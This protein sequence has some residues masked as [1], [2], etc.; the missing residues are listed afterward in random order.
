MSEVADALRIPEF[1]LVVLVGASGAGKSTFAAKHFLPT[2]VISSDA[3][4][5]LVSDD[6][7]NQDVSREAFEVLEFVA[8]KRLSAR[9]LTVIDATN[10]Q[11]DARK[12]LVALARKYHAMPVAIALNVPEKLCVARNRERSDRNFGSGVIRRQVQSLRRSLRALK[13]EGF[14]YTHRLNSVDEVE[15]ATI[16]RQPLW[17]DRRGDHGPFDIIGDIHGCRAE[18]ESLLQE[19]GY[20]RD[21][22]D[23]PYRHPEGRRAVF[24]G[25]L[26]DRGPDTPG[27]IRTVMGMVQAE[28]GLC[29]AGNHDQKLHRKLRGRDVRITHGLA[30]SLTQLENQPPEFVEQAMGFFDSLLSHYWLDDGKLVVAHAGLRE[31]LQGRAS[32]KVREFALYGDTTGETDDF[33]LPERLDWAADYRG[34]AAVVYG[35]TPVHEPEWLNNTINIDTGCVF[36]G[37]LS[38]L[39]YP[40]R[41]IVAVPAEQVWYEPARPLPGASAASSA[42]DG[43]TAQQRY[44]TTLDLSDVVGKRLVNTALRRNVVIR[45][46]NAVAALEVMSRFA[47]DPRWLIYLPPTMSPCETAADGDLLER[48][49]EAFA[50]FRSRG[51]SEVVCEAKH[52]G[53]RAVIVLCRDGDVA[54]SRFGIESPDGGVCFTRTGRPFFN[55]RVLIGEFLGAVRSA[56]DGAG[57][58]DELGTDW[59]CLDTEL[60]PWSAKAQELLRNQYAAVGAAATAALPATVSALEQ[61]AARGADVAELRERFGTRRENAERFVAA[62]QEYCWPVADLQDLRVAPFHLLA[63]EGAMHADKDH[64]WHMAW[65]EKLAAAGEPLVMATEHRKVSVTNPDEEQAATEWWETHTAAGGEG[66]VVKPL[67]FID[68]GRKGLVQPAVKVRGREY[69]RIIFGADYTMPE[70]LERLRKR[71][72]SANRSMALREFALGLEALERF[73][74]REPLRRVHEC[75]FAVLA[76]ESEPVDPRL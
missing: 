58:W 25:D 15:A 33:G 39:R 16:E 17:T 55:D 41:E 12:P 53:S 66:M 29:V 4:R 20:R 13:R 60:M 68:R 75:A 43:L 59:V 24:V 30:E 52:M 5:G 14:R 56:C 23:T 27:V 40:E 45:E 73:V 44:D 42:A 3:C 57:L 35:H 1:S 2:E 6:T 61:A 76:L 48:P 67:K 50:Y 10:V 22:E 54:R 31:D 69:L 19:L 62:Y 34:R 63:S 32:G 71:G 64:L 18:L 36:G 65:A 46:G 51:I 37:S 74:R 11:A 49:A 47:V 7:N 8:A 38:A 9:R 21:G 70:H 72:L 28:S 26:V